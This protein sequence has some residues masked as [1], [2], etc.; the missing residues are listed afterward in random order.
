METFSMKYSGV[1]ESRLYN[2]S[3]S[4]ATAKSKSPA[5]TKIDEREL[6]RLQKQDYWLQATRAKLMMDLVFVSYDLFRLKRARDSVKAFAGLTAAFLSTAKLFDRH[7]SALT[8]A[9]GVTL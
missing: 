6:A 2:E 3:L 5:A 9:L 4:G 8:K 1:A 7:K